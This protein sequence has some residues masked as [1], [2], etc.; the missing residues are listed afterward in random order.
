[1]Q[2]IG[3][4]CCISGIGETRAKKLLTEHSITELTQLPDLDLVKASTVNQAVN[5]RKVFQVKYVPK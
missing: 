5:L 1:M 3:A 2:A 4:L